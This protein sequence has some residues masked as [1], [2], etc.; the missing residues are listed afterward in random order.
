MPKRSILLRA[1]V[2]R[3]SHLQVNHATM[4]FAA[5][6]IVERMAAR[7]IMIAPVIRL[8]ANATATPVSARLAVMN[9]TGR[10]FQR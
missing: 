5:Q 1:G 3:E 6:I 2:R 8:T 9:K 7:S 4:W 10:V